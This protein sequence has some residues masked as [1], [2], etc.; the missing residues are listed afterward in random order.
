M[1]NVS[2][3]NKDGGGG[4]GAMPITP[5]PNVSAPGSSLPGGGSTTGD[6]LTQLM[7][8]DRLNKDGKVTAGLQNA[9]SGLAGMLGGKGGG[10]A[11]PGGTDAGALT[12]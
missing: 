2:M 12:M 4:G 3:I 10:G 6:L 5:G 7:I 8:L 11:L 1:V 9:G